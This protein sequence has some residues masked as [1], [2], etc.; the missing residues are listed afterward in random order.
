M[1]LYRTFIWAR[2][3]PVQTSI[4]IILR[5]TQNQTY[6]KNCCTSL[7]WMEVSKTLLERNS[8]GYASV[9]ESRIIV[10]IAHFLNRDS[11]NIWKTTPRR[12]TTKSCFLIIVS[13]DFIFPLYLFLN[14]HVTALGCKRL[15]VDTG[16]YDCLHR[17]N[18]QLNNDRILE[19]N[20]G[21]ILTNKGKPK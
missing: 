20:E 17:P 6:S 18:M 5:L 16:Y 10:Y 3:G 8:R 19:V 1:R 4:I 15:I 14:W 11:C 12:N 9:H 21:G 7:C 2:V 13:P